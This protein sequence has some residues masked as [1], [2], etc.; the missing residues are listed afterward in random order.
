MYRRAVSLIPKSHVPNYT[1]DQNQPFCHTVVWSVHV[2]KEKMGGQV[3]CYDDSA[4][5][6]CFLVRFK[7]TFHISC[8]EPRLG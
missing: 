6:R 8:L 3:S 2:Q 1:L 4:I 5:R 7:P